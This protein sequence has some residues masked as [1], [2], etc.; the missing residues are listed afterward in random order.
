[1][2]Y[3]YTRIPQYTLV[4][5]KSGPAMFLLPLSVSY[6]LRPERRADA[7]GHFGRTAPVAA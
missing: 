2:P 1:V 3:R 5:M 6:L 7:A 4:T